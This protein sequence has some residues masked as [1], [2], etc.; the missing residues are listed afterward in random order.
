MSD[1][2][3]NRNFVYHTDEP[4]PDCQNCGRQALAHRWFDYRCPADADGLRWKQ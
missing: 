1:A 4:M 3:P 2:K